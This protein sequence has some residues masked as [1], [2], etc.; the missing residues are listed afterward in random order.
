MTG[1]STRSAT[2]SPP[3][4]RCHLRGLRS[5]TL[6]GFTEHPTKAQSVSVSTSSSSR[7]ILFPLTC[8]KVTARSLSSSREASLTLPVFG[9]GL[10]GTCTPF[11]SAC[12]FAFRDTMVE[13]TS[14][15]DVSATISFQQATRCS[16]G[17][18]SRG[19][20]CPS[21]FGSQSPDGDWDDPITPGNDPI[22]PGN[23]RSTSSTLREL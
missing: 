3:G 11:D 10:L 16:L 23:G 2:P 21:F 1:S 22:T 14:A 18:L 6:A 7:E 19:R 8:S 5:R 12:C 20:I 4:C 17:R 9:A 13:V 15:G